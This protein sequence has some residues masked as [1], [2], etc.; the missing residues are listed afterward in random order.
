MDS[1]RLSRLFKAL[2]DENRIRIVRLI[3]ESGELCAC[4]ILA[5]FDLAQPTLS[6]HMKTL[7]TAGL[8]TARKEGR[9]IHYALAPGALEEIASFAAALSDPHLRP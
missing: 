7:R 4:K 6:H 1:E 5:E 3:A 9:W 2:G 8:V